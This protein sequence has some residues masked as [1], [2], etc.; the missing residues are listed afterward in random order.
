MVRDAGLA[1]LAAPKLGTS[2]VLVVGTVLG[3]L[4]V[5]L[6]EDE[7]VGARGVAIG[8]RTGGT[9]LTAINS[10]TRGIIS[11]LS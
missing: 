6:A 2:G 4:A 8:S 10:S 3:D 1:T 5:D 7:L 9:V 11:K